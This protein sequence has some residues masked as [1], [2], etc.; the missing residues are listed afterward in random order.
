MPGNNPGPTSL[1]R[2]SIGLGNTRL[3]AAMAL[4]IL[5]ALS[6]AVMADGIERDPL[7]RLEARIAHARAVA[8]R[9][10]TRV[11]QTYEMIER[12]RTAIAHSLDAAR[13][14]RDAAR[15]ARPIRHGD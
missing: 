14:L 2:A 10:R 6:T 8:A 9:T 1:V 7:V 12:T 4:T 3:H 13:R 15:T 5:L 11:E